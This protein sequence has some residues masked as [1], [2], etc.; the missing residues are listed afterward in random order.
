MGTNISINQH[1]RSDLHFH[2]FCHRVHGMLPQSDEHFFILDSI[3]TFIHEVPVDSRHYLMGGFKQLRDLEIPYKIPAV[4]LV[5]VNDVKRGHIQT[6]VFLIFSVD[7][8]YT[9]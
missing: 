9:S 1:A 3:R 2:F 7:S 5:V 4:F 8:F 6:L